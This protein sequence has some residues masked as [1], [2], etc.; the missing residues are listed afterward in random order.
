MNSLGK[1]PGEQLTELGRQYWRVREEHDRENLEGSTRRRIKQD[2]AEVVDRFERLLGHWV[3]DDEL[4][5]AWRLYLYDAAD[6]PDQPRLSPPPLFRG[7]TQTDALLEI[8]A[9]DDGGYDILIDGSHVR[10][11]DVPWHWDLEDLGPIQIGEWTCREIFDAPEKA[12][13][14]LRAFVT[15][16][17]AGPPWDCAPALFEDGLIDTDFGLT[18]RG[19]RR[20][21]EARL[22]AETE[23]ARKHYC[24]IVAD[25]ARARILTLTKHAFEIEEKLDPLQPVSDLT[26]PEQRMRDGEQFTDSRPGIRREGPHGPRHG[27]SDRR[28]KSRRENTRQFAR[29]VADEAARTW[30]QFPSSRVVVVAEPRMLGMLRPE[31]ARQLDDPSLHEVVEF[32][33]DLT[34]LDVPAVHDALAKEKLLPERERLAPLQSMRTPNPW[35]EER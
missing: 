29:L 4:R 9:A 15:G 16:P 18:P 22:E 28:D 2:M 13:G 6:A 10:H 23:R 11:H 1:D 5:D 8:R 7:H 34:W 25:A 33:R 3:R 17:G 14:A 35:Q 20:L 26:N 24:V 19:A 27:V 32:P 21:G 12:V 30:G 31:I